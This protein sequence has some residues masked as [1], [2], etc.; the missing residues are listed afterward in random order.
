MARVGVSCEGS[1]LRAVIT[2]IK[3]KKNQLI[4]FKCKIE[5]HRL[6]LGL[7]P[8]VIID[9]LPHKALVGV[10]ECAGVWENVRGCCISVVC[11][12]AR[13]RM[14]HACALCAVWY[15]RLCCSGHLAASRSRRRAGWLEW[16][17]VLCWK[18]RG[19][20]VEFG[21]VFRTRS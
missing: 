10:R 9:A 17:A 4:H 6:F 14:A 16:C 13:A 12:C 5:S 19:R 2:R 18:G 7:A 21:C 3:K 8:C 1:P 15:L 20:W 11:V